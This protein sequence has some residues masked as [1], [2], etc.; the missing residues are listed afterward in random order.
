M[1]RC[2]TVLSLEEPIELISLWPWP[3]VNECEEGERRCDTVE[4]HDGSVKQ[5][6]SCV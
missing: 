2:R 3:G 5:L 1:K 4:L 6:S